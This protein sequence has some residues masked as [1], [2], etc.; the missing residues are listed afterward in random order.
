MQFKFSRMMGLNPFRLL[1]AFC[2]V[3][4]WSKS[5]IPTLILYSFG[6][7]AKRNRVAIMSGRRMKR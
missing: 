4:V 1:N 2:D 7:S 6:F 3:S 5:Q